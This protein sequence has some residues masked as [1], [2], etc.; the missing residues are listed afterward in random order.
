ML[1]IR[2]ARWLARAIDTTAFGGNEQT[3]RR[4][5]RCAASRRRIAGYL[6]L[7][8]LEAVA[9]TSP[10][11]VAWVTGGFGP[12][13]DRGSAAAD[14]WAV[15][16]RSEAT[17][18]TTVVE[19]DRLLEDYDPARHGFGLVAVDWHDPSAMARACAE[20]AGVEQGALASD[21]RAELGPDVG[22]D[23]VELRLPLCAAEQVELRGL[24]AVA[25]TAL[26]EA[27]RA[28]RPGRST[29]REIQ[30][31]IACRLEAAGADSPVLIVGGD[32]RVRRLRHPVATGARANELVMAVVV[33]RR[34]GLHVA[35]T[36]Y[37]ATAVAARGLRPVLARVEQV[38][39]AVLAATVPGARYVEV[40]A[41][42]DE[43]YERAGARGAWRDHYQGGPIGFAQREFEIAP[44]GPYGPYGLT[45]V[46]VGNAIAWNPSL[47]GGGKCEDTYLVEEGR[48]SR[49]T[50]QQGWPTSTAGSASP[51]A[52]RPGVLVVD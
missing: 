14:V 24:G 41:K 3:Y 38:D 32:E 12:P 22:A 37:A 36:R 20:I 4:G 42:L 10:A 23:L 44:G 1:D 28:W 7:R 6:E 35:A 2:R 49:V 48:L 29:D 8:G 31:A 33:A 50:V 43:A 16:S 17:L 25:A 40:L 47:G 18:V 46:K 9:L 15:V 51:L 5:E 45:E 34:L 26:G 13:V 30:A 27:L 19:Q 52:E 21:G 11:S 39:D